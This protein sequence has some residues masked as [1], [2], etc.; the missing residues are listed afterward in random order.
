MIETGKEKVVGHVNFV[1]YLCNVITW[2]SC[3]NPGHRWWFYL[4][5]MICQFYVP[6]CSIHLFQVLR[7]KQQ[8]PG[9]LQKILAADVFLTQRFCNWADCFLPFRSLRLH[10]KVL[11]VSITC[12]SLKWWQFPYASLFSWNFYI[13]T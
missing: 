13:V 3:G 6:A 4:N 8:V 2:D 5:L 12:I 9:I 1:A 11:E 7:E 10:Y